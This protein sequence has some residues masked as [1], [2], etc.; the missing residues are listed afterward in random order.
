M[1]PVI[2]AVAAY[3]VTAAAIEAGIVVAGSLG[4][5]A[6]FTGT[7]MAVSM[8]TNALM[9]VNKYEAPQVD[10]ESFDSGILLNKAGSSEP[11][12]VVYG[13]RRV[14]MTRVFLEATGDSNEYLHYVGVLGEGPISAINTVYLNDIPSTDPKFSGY[15]DIYKHLG[16]DDQLADSNLMAACSSWTQYHRL[17]GVAYIYVRLKYDKDVFAGGLPKFTADVDGRL[18]YDPRDEQ[19]KFSR[20]PA[21]CIRDYLTNNR[22]GRGIPEAMIDDTDS[23]ASANYCDEDVVVGGVTQD[24]YTC[25]GL[26][27][28]DDSSLSN[29]QKMISSCRGMLIFSGGLY[30]LLIDKPESATFAFTEDNITGSWTISLGTKKNMFNRMR[31][32]F[33]NP[34]RSWQED[35]APVDSEALRALDNGLVLEKQIDL[36][37]TANI[38][39]AKQITTINLN[40]SRQQIACQFSAFIE[41]LRCEVGRVVTITH[42]TPGWSGKKFRIC[43]MALKNNDE[44]NVTV[45]EYADS[46]YDFGTIAAADAT[47]DTNL[48]DLTTALPPV[49]LETSEEMYFTGK[50]FMSRVTLTW[51]APQDAFVIEYDVEYKLS[52]GTEWI[53]STTTKTRSRLISNLA[54]GQYD[55]RVRSVNTMLVGSAWST[56]SRFIFGK[57]TPPANVSEFWA[58][59]S[60]GGLILSWTAVPDIDVDHY[61]LRWHPDSS[62]GTWDKAI[63]VGETKGTSLTL[64]AAKPGIYFVKA[65]DKCDPPKESVNAKSVI[66]D[67]IPAILRWNVTETLNEDP[68]W[69][70]SKTKMAKVGN[71]LILDIGGPWDEIADFD[72]VEN[73]DGYDVQPS[74]VGY[75]ETEAVDLGSVQ[76]VRC[77]GEAKFFGIDT[78]SLFDNITNFDQIADFDGEINNVGVQLQI[79]L[80]QNGVDWGA[81]QPFIVGDYTAR[82]FK[83]RIKA[84]SNSPTQYL[85]VEDLVFIVDVPE[86]VEQDQDVSV[87]AG[88]SSIG[89]ATPYILDKPI[90]RII[91]QSAQAGDT[92]RLTNIA[93]AGFDVQVLDNSGNGVARTVD[94]Y[95][96]GY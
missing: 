13:S 12:P 71:S 16:A 91:I 75:Y 72:A 29:T 62:V 94:W 26:I 1:P 67:D 80:S 52:S 43:N 88:G 76:T 5:T 11:I 69:T 84:Y 82:A 93:K 35:I 22:Y 79:A 54:P 48:P 90:I 6:I 95:A 64:P 34:A 63:D 32:R 23:A 36:P 77:S 66:L 37:F 10:T 15:V 24:R 68:D 42:G 46:V 4:A 40:Q 70:G 25:D 38:S 58:N 50:D 20:N 2:A 96:T 47:P 57:T 53:R 92:Y 51:N 17:R 87:A 89:F 85:Q 27:N 61:G 8:V 78:E 41:G 74:T 49:D 21:L 30:K 59:A 83:F 73:I 44:V 33:Y 45:R 65:L 60:I 86:R 9:G 81:W 3:A 28:V 31:A 14:G 19:T 56:I 55:F 18:V 7:M 39:T